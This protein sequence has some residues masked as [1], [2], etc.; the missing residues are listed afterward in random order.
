MSGPAEKRGR[1]KRAGSFRVCRSYDPG[2]ESHVLTAVRR[3]DLLVEGEAWKFYFKDD[4]KARDRWYAA[5]RGEDEIRRLLMGSCRPD[6]WGC[7]LGIDH[8]EMPEE[9]T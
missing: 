7:G 1:C 6:V 3:G 9:T 4:R 2:N 5:V 8:E